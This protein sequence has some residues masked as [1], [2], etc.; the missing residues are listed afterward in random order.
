MYAAI[1]EQ[2]EDIQ[3][4]EYGFPVWV[5][6]QGVIRNA[7]LVLCEDNPKYCS[8]VYMPVDVKSTTGYGIDKNMSIEETMPDIKK[9]VQKQKVREAMDNF[10]DVMLK[11]GS[12][13]EDHKYLEQIE[14]WVSRQVQ[15]ISL[16]DVLYFLDGFIQM[17]YQP[18]G[19][20]LDGFMEIGY[21]P[22]YLVRTMLRHLAVKFNSIEKS[23]ANIIHVLFLI[24]VSRDASPELMQYLHAYV[25]ENVQEFDSIE[26]A[27]IC[28]AFKTMNTKLS[29]DGNLLTTMAEKLIQELRDTVQKR[30]QSRM[31]M[32]LITR[33]LQAFAEARFMNVTFYEKL[34]DVIC[35]ADWGI[36]SVYKGSPLAHLAYAYGSVGVQHGRLFESIEQHLSVMQNSEIHN[37][38]KFRL[39]DLA[40]LCDSYSHLRMNIPKFLIDEVIYRMDHGIDELDTT[41]SNDQEK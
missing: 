32:Y 30:S 40:H 15:M 13:K 18:G 6:S 23:P 14:K 1:S 31:N 11:A 22:K 5:T 35:D 9:L 24:G 16:P 4:N 41:S 26:I 17:S 37:F 19:Q 27:I 8:T 21:Q 39:K 36:K 10:G 2:N 3:T 28:W 7:H 25:E 29:K 38:R 12:E 20:V 33:I 34:G